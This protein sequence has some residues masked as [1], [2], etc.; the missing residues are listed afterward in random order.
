[1]LC[2]YTAMVLQ[3]SGYSHISTC[4]SQVTRRYAEFSAALVSI[5]Q[6]HPDEQVG[7]GPIPM[8]PFLS[9]YPLSHSASQVDKCLSA[10]QSEVE[11][12]ILRMAAEFPS[13][14]EQLIFLINN[15]DMMLS[16]LSVS[17]H[18]YGTTCEMKP[19]VIKGFLLCFITS[20]MRTVL[21]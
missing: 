19:M 5:N 11:N 8:I 17:C 15:Y 20:I 3:L 12:F 21:S 18:S 9:S 4:Y 1:M 6:S 2:H 7:L 16:V 10:L 14:K 13:R